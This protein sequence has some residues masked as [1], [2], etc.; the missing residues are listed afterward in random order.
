MKKL[1]LVRTL[2]F[3]NLWVKTM[4]VNRRLPEVKHLE[5]A[6]FEDP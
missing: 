3:F 4:S 1:K 6:V 5:I 2:R